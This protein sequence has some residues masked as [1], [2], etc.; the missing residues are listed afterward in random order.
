[1]LKKVPKNRPTLSDL[2]NAPCMRE[3]MFK[4]FKRAK[5]INKHFVGHPSLATV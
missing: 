3:A 1:M 5:H 4:A 2:I